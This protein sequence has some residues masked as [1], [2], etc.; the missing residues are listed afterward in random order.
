MTSS[1]FLLQ[2]HFLLPDRPSCFKENIQ[3]LRR[4]VGDRL[5]SP[6]ATTCLRSYS[7]TWLFLLFLSMGSLCSFLKPALSEIPSLSTCLLSFLLLFGPHPHKS[8]L[9]LHGHSSRLQIPEQNFP[10][11]PH[12]PLVTSLNHLY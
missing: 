11:T 2:Y 1:H 6:H 5:L 4:E 7:L 8:P 3:A 10:L 9:S 12:S